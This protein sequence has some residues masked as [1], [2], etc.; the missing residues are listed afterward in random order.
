MAFGSSFFSWEVSRSFRDLCVVIAV[1][2]VPA[3]TASAANSSNETNPNS[4]D[5]PQIFAVDCLWNETSTTHE[6]SDSSEKLTRAFSSSSVPQ[7]VSPKHLLGWLEIAE[8]AGE[9]HFVMP[10]TG[11]LLTG[12]F[13][14]VLADGRSTRSQTLLLENEIR[15]TTNIGHCEVID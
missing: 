8:I 13:L 1:S 14:T 2:L 11:S 5:L 12:D 7:K 9:R 4:G 10:S 3:N 15:V 6:Y